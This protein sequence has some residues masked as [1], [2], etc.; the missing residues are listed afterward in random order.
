MKCY[1]F[2]CRIYPKFSQCLQRNSC[3]ERPTG[4]QIVVISTGILFLILLI[5]VFIQ[6][7]LSQSDK[8][9]LPPQSVHSNPGVGGK[10]DRTLFSYGPNVHYGIVLDC[11]SSGTRVYVYIW[12]P[13]SGNQRDL[14]NIQQLKDQ[15]NQPVV[16]KVSPGLSTNLNI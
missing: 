5:I 13:H 7:K 16:M 8:L 11:G 2:P 15:D 9:I 4:R 1:L 6:S 14:L 12:P 10:I 3:A